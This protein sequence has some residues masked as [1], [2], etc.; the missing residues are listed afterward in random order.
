MRLEDKL[1]A[2]RRRYKK[3]FMSIKSAEETKIWHRC[4]HTAFFLLF[5]EAQTSVSKHNVLKNTEIGGKCVGI[6]I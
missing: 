5:R 6:K 2:E 1:G 4:Q 3:Q